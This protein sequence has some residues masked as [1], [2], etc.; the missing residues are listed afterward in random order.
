MPLASL[1]AQVQGQVQGV[2]FRAFVSRHARGM[3]LTGYVRNLPDGKR[4][5]VVAEGEKAHLEALLKFLRTGPSGARVE[6]V[7]VKWGRSTGSFKGFE[8]KY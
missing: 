5:E 6:R 2:F 3:G 4:V 1:Q 7:E 8:I